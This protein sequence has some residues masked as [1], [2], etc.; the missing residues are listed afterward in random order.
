LSPSLGEKVCDIRGQ[1]TPANSKSSSHLERCVLV[2]NSDRHGDPHL[3][4]R[5]LICRMNNGDA[6]E[7]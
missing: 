2:A 4:A 7:P 5:F 6:G 1:A 3:I